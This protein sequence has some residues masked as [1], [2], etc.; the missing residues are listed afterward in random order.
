[1]GA[2]LAQRQRLKVFW[3][4]MKIRNDTALAKLARCTRKCANHWRVRFEQG[5]FSLSDAPR[6]GRPRALD[7]TDLRRL[8]ALMKRGPKKKGPRATLLTNKHRSGDKKAVCVRTVTRAIAK[9]FEFGVVPPESISAA[10]V[11]KRE[12]ATSPEKI[13]A[14]EENLKFHVFID[15]ATAT[16]KA[17]EPVKALRKRL[18]WHEPGERRKQSL[19]GWHTQTFYAAS[20]LGPD[21][22]GVKS[23]LIF[24]PGPRGLTS[25][26]VTGMFLPALLEW[27][28][29]AVGPRAVLVW[30]L[31]G[32]TPHTAKATQDWMDAHGMV[33]AEHPPSSPDL[34][35]HE[36]E[37]LRFKNRLE[38]SNARPRDVHAFRAHARRHW[39][40]IPAVHI[41]HDIEALP[42]VMR[43]VHARP[44][45]HDNKM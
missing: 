15:A 19:G 40:A 35:P 3:Q 24:V 11:L 10:N 44:G 31:D 2:Y 39:N 4:D 6:S 1:M 41:K 7:S 17:N 27:A 22:S 16:L 38:A 13:E 26:V 21:G 36:K 42:S 25:E 45:K 9:N 28:E 18:D 37:W 33:R 30:H 12:A 32:A 23:Q 5:D 43:R 34:N 20:A 14:L 29:E 8:K